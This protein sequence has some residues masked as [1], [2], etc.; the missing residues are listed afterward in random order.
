[1]AAVNVLEL[2]SKQLLTIPLPSEK[3]GDDITMEKFILF[4]MEYVSKPI[5]ESLMV[6]DRRLVMKV[7]TGHVQIYHALLASFSSI[8]RHGMFTP[9]TLH[10]NK[11]LLRGRRKQ[12][13]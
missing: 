12:S 11:H 2:P 7:K 9:R 5:I 10:I 13:L 4:L 3:G 6:G 8:T 1:M